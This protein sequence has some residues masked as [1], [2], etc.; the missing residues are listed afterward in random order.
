MPSI[1]IDYNLSDSSQNTK[2]AIRNAISQKEVF[3]VY[4]VNAQIFCHGIINRSYQELIQ[5]G[6]INTCDGINVKRLVKWT[7]HKTIELYPGPDLFEDLVVKNELGTLKHVFIGGT[8][9]VSNGLK[10][11]FG[12]NYNRFYSPPFVTH[13]SKFD[14]EYLATLINDFDADII[15]I[16]L[17]APKQEYVINELKN[18]LS[19]GVIVGVGAAFNFHSGIASLGRAPKIWRD[20]KLEWMYRLHQEPKRIFKR[21]FKNFFLLIKGYIYYS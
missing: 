19:K 14:Y 18:H 16:G 17:G 5:K 21:Q 9:E 13:Y 8:E 6:D 3:A 1:Q 11:R 4:V 20:L 10:Q 15:W 12:T 2:S 7:S